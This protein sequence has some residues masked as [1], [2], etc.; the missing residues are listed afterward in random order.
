VNQRVM[1]FCGYLFVGV[2]VVSILLGVLVSGIGKISAGAAC[3]IISLV[4]ML[5]G[6]CMAFLR[7]RYMVRLEKAEEAEKVKEV[8]E[9]SREDLVTLATD[10]VVS[11]MIRCKGVALSTSRVVAE[12]VAQ[13]MMARMSGLHNEEQREAVFGEVDKILEDE[14]AA[15]KQAMDGQ[16]ELARK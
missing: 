14:M 16:I 6:M 11:D 10:A 3:G 8:P 15:V 4:S 5:A 1:T 2:L 13:R 9:Q 12:R 7:E